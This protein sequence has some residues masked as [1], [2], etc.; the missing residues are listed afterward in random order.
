ME[1]VDVEV[2]WPAAGKLVRAGETNID[3]KAHAGRALVIKIQ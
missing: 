2:T 3:I 1:L